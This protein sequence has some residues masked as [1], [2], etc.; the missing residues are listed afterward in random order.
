MVMSLGRFTNRP[1]DG[2]WRKGAERRHCYAA[3]GLCFE[4]SF[5]RGVDGL[6]LFLPKLALLIF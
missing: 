4:F 1:Y 5:P 2:G 6:F 3:Q